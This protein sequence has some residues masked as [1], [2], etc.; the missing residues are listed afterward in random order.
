MQSSQ[1]DFPDESLLFPS[2]RFV[3]SRWNKCR[4]IYLRVVKV[5]GESESGNIL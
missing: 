5:L 3:H 1:R 2:K 4:D